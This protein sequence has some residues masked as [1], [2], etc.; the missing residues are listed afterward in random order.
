MQTWLAQQRLTTRSRACPPHKLETIAGE[1][2]DTFLPA[3][4][5]SP[6]AG[7]YY[8]A[9]KIVIEVKAFETKF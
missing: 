9:M 1:L 6:V 3:N 7:K 4:Y 8:V 5:P 2:L